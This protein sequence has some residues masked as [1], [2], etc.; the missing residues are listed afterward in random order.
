MSLIEC[1]PNFSE[2]RRPEVVGAIRDAIGAVPGARVLDVSTDAWHNRSVITFAAAPEVIGDAAFA[3]IRE[4]QRLIDLNAHAGCHPRLG[5]ADVVP[6]VP[7]AG[8]SMD[9]CVRV[10]R[11]LGR[12]VGDELAIPVY[13]YE[14][15]ATR[16]GRRNLADVRRGGFEGLR[17]RVGSDPAAEPDFGPSRLHPSCGAVA[18]G[19]RGLLVAFN[20]FLGTAERD[21]PVASAVARAVRASSPGGLRG[22]KALAFEVDGLAQ[23]SMNL[24]EPEVTTML[25]AFDRV[26]EEAAARGAAVTS[27]ELVGLAP[28]GQLDAEGAA[29]MMLRDFDPG[30]SIEARLR[31][32]GLA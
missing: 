31:A 8:T 25:Q 2:G 5:A 27:S 24:V 18:I 14:R 23:V 16:P 9:D 28:E 13:L 30:R 6:F 21:M 20:V 26:R 12:R 15:A 32:A 17:E 4:A 7:L 22:V 11:E 29:R 19:A 3:G 10:A 1:V